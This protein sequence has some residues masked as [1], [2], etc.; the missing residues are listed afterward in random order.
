MLGEPE[1]KKV[2]DKIKEKY[3]VENVVL[4]GER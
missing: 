4:L 3:M 2:L 1:R